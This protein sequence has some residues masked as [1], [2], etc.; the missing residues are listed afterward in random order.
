MSSLLDLISAAMNPDLSFS[1]TVQLRDILARD[2]AA[3]SRRSEE[4]P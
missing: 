2:G 4:R 1:E 3:T